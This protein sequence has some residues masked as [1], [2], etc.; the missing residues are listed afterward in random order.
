[1]P[2]FSTLCDIRRKVS[3]QVFVIWN[4][5]LNTVSGIADKPHKAW[6]ESS[7]NMREANQVALRLDNNNITYIDK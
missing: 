3:D 7:Q 6:N 4:A 2:F 5:G 1:M